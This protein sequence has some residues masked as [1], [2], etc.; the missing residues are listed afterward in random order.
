VRKIQ[1]AQTKMVGKHFVWFPWTH[2]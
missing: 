1:T 2:T